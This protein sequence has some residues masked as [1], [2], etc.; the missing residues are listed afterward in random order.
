MTTCYHLEK[1]LFFVHIPKCA[2]TSVGGE[3]HPRTGVWDGSWL[4]RVLP[5]WSR[6]NLPNGH[7]PVAAIEMVTGHPVG[8]WDRIIAVIR[9]PFAQQVSQYCFWRVRGWSNSQQGRGSHFDDLTACGLRFEDWV[10]HPASLGPNT[11]TGVAGAL[12]AGGYY[13]WYLMDPATG[14]IPENVRVVKMEDLQA[15]L[16]GS[17]AGLGCDFEPIESSNEVPDKMSWEYWYTPESAA[18]VKQKF[19][20]SLAT[21]YPELRDFSGDPNLDLL[22]HDYLYPELSHVV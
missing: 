11:C 2:G 21:H 3:V 16:E 15:G 12:A 10:Q 13:R 9:N 20:W 22:G 14:Q 4:E 19:A 18:A 5:G 6:D 8:W 17:L 7:Q 1:R